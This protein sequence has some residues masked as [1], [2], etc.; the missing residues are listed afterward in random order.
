MKYL[1]VLVLIIVVGVVQGGT[2]L[3]DGDKIEDH[4]VKRV[5]RSPH[6]GYDDYGYG[7]YGGYDGYGHGDYGHHG[8]GGYGDY[9]DY[10][11][12]YGHHHHHYG[13]HHHHHW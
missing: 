3:L 4:G 2:T 6:W 1:G 9:G 13:H 10:G 7:G 5:V 11:Y 12:D 8:Y